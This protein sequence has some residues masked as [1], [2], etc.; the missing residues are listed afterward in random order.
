MA[1]RSLRERIFQT[2]T[3]EVGGLLLVVPLFAL[4]TA[5]SGAESMSLLALISLAVMLWSPLHN[6]AF[7]WMDLHLAGR[8]ASDRPHHWRVVHAASHELSSVLVTFPIVTLVGGF[9]IADALA[10]EFGLTVAYTVYAY[11]FHLVYD[12]MR[13]VRRRPA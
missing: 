8:L 5:K 12:Q 4:A 6:I 11:A 10:A 1:L 2:I 7:D 3:F 9:G 13:P